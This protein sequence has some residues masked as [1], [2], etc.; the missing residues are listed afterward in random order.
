MTLWKCFICDSEALCAHRE[1]E[2]MAMIV[3]R[4]R[5]V[6]NQSGHELQALIRA[7]QREIERK[8][9]GSDKAA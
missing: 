3:R 1:P 7:Y 5:E 2:L 9:V 4:E 6:T 8:P